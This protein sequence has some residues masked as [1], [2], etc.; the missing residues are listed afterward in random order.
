MSFPVADSFSF[1][2]LLRALGEQLKLADAHFDLVIIGGSALLAHK[3][4]DRATRDV[5]VVAIRNSAGILESAEPLPEALRIARD[6][7]ARD[8]GISEDWLNAGPTSLL[9]LGLPEGFEDRVTAVA[10]NPWL[11]VHLA[12]R[13]DLIHFKLYALADL[14]PGKHDQD[15][16]SLNPT[17]GE[18][19]LA[20]RWTQTHDPSPGFASLLDAALNLLGMPD[21]S[22]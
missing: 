1:D 20:A 8:F 15:L 22:L 7:V 18:L 12:S 13:L 17:A 10:I 14:G 11:T 4:I 6:R 21:E 19:V 2:R 16:R 5:D 3:F 9:D